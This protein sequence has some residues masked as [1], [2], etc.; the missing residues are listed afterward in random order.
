MSL[1]LLLLDHRGKNLNNFSNCPELKL[2]TVYVVNDEIKN[3]Y[4][5]AYEDISVITYDDITN[6]TKIKHSYDE[7][8]SY[9]HLMHKVIRYTK[10]QIDNINTINYL[11]YIHLSF[12]IDFFENNKIDL[13]FSEGE[14]GQVDLKIPMEV[15][16]SKNI[17]VFVM[18]NITASTQ[19]WIHGLKDYNTKEF[20]D[21]SKTSWIYP[22][23]SKD[24][25]LFN[26]KHYK[27]TNKLS[28]KEIVLLITFS[29][30]GLFFL[31]FL[32]Y[33]IDLK[34]NFGRETITMKEI[35]K[36]YIKVNNI[37]NYYKKIA[38][39]DIDLNTKYIY[40]PLHFEPEASFDSRIDL[41]SQLLAIKMIS[42]TLPEGWKLYVKEHPSQYDIFNYKRWYYPI[43]FTNYK[44]ELFYNTINKFKNVDLL[45]YNITSKELIKN[46]MCVVT[47][48]GTVSYEAISEKKPLMIF[49]SEA[50]PLKYCQDVFKIKAPSDVVDTM[51]KLKNNFIPNYSDFSKIENNYFFEQDKET[52]QPTIP[53]EVL[54]EAL[55]QWNYIV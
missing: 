6:N 41:P 54:L 50:S 49:G 34:V 12:W 26:T 52:E 32:N 42:D 7:I 1:N 47:F 4:H 9:E 28:L 23:V 40:Y 25:H 5:T 43:N 33:F 10:R 38:I 2:H 37:K 35:Y 29:K 27:R 31:S 19:K 24:N 14:S 45:N 22:K 11:Y 20:I 8:N 16:K 44:D 55:E 39:K 48:V 3:K 36:W 18:E 13:I 17:K 30:T 51:E 46:T 15:A 53:S 21:F